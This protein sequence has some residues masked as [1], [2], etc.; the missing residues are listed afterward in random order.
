MK[1]ILRQTVEGLGGPGSIVS[2][3]DG[4]ARNYLIPQRLALHYTPGN[5]KR[6]GQEKKRLAVIEAKLKND[7]EALAA[8]FVSTH[9]I[10]EKKSGAEGVLYGSVTPAEVAEALG[11]KGL[12]VD[13]KRLVLSEPIKRLGDYHVTVRLHP[14]VSVD[15]LVSVFPEGGTMPAAPAIEEGKAPEA[16]ADHEGEGAQLAEAAHT[17]LE[18]REE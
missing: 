7:A 2:V 3:K 14:E 15:I 12:T 1:V 17:E 16:A 9:L 18:E 4:Y 8:Q 5:L 11:R 6:I 13:R 10:F